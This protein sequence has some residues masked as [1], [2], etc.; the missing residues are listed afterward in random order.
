[1]KVLGITGGIGSG[2]SIVCKVFAQLGIPVYEADAEVK[3]MYLTHDAMKAGLRNKF[4]GEL[5][6][7]EGNPDTKKFAAYFFNNEPALQQ[8]NSLVHPYVKEHFAKWVKA[9][10]AAPY[11]IKEAA[12]LFESGSDLG[13]DRIVTVSAPEDLRFRRVMARDRRSRSE[14]EKIIQNQWTD[15]ERKEASDFV[16]TNDEKQMV[17]PQ[18]LAI[19]RQMMK[20][21]ALEK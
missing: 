1:M 2:K 21:A 19:H 8:L 3:K 20:L 18:V 12:I 4:P 7:K 15:E 6:T 10:S 11:V 5:F 9:N 14:V 13:C 16:I 17:L